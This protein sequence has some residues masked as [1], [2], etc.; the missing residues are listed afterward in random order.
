MTPALA[1]LRAGPLC[2]LQDG[3]RRGFLR[4]GVTPAG[5]MD[6]IAQQG[7]NLLAGNPAGAA[8]IEAG[9]GGLTLAAEGAPLRLGLWARGFRV[10]RDGSALPTRMALTLRPGARLDIAPGHAGLWTCVAV[11]GSFDVPPVMGSLSTHLRSGLGPMGGGALA[12]GQRLPVRQGDM[13]TEAPEMALF[14]PDPPGETPIRFI[15]GPQ[16]DHFT[17]AALALF[18][19]AAWRIG[20]RSDRMAFR[21]DGPALAH[22]G[23]HDIV[24]DG[25]ALGAIQ[26]PGDGMPLV[27]MADRQPTGGYPKLGCVIRADLPRLAQTRPG[28]SLRFAAVTVDQAVAALRAAIPDAEDLRRRL[29]VIRAVPQ[30]R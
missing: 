12:T 18:T 23:G 27:L 30:G 1:V 8:V 29:R 14:D 15:P 5:P 2:T 6:W 11:A 7:A 13:A 4:F 19:A 25:V 24:S 3:G 9:P 16:D 17:P 22:A 21:L 26:V 10:T 28:Q 20:P